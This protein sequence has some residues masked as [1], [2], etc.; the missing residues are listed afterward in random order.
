VREGIVWCPHCN[1][2]HKLGEAYCPNTG[3]RLERRIHDSGVQVRSHPLEGTII[4]GK[5]EV[6]RR[7]GVGGM[8]EVFEAHNRVLQR[9]V[10]LK[11][12]GGT[13]ADAAARLR[14]EARVIASMQHPNICDLYDIGIMPDGSP[15]L[16]LE[17][18]TGETLHACIARE[19]RLG[20]AEAVEIFSQIL[21]AAQHAH[22]KGVV[23]RDLKPANVFL[24]E[25]FGT[26]PLVKLLDFG[27]AMDN[28]GRMQKM[29]Q[30]GKACGTPQY[31]SPEQLRGRPVDPRSDLFT[32]GL[33]LFEVLAG[34]HP[35]AAPALVETTIRIA[36]EEP[37]G[38]AKLRTRVPLA[39]ADLIE[40]VLQKDPARRPQSAIEMQTVLARL[41][42]AN[43]D[44]APM[45]D[46]AP[47]F[48]R[49]AIDSSYSSG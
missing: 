36:Y 49:L 2:P 4:D 22:A 7:I 9:N 12:V 44:E 38:L 40:R 39:L 43:D 45:S 42:L 24:V 20:V 14:R 6:L 26:A 33:M 18:L 3:A 37:I 29:T 10:A 21:S 11:I 19:R 34:K 25:R 41:D 30:P 32:I 15:Y 27:L 23:H 16:V 28:A 35:F 13:N 47:S 31:M 17:R 46:S 8:G 48:P 5:F 1:E